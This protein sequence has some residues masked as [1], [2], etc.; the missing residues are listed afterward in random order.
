MVT[1]PCDCVFPLGG[2]AVA[3]LLGN[4]SSEQNSYYLT[5][6][7]KGEVKMEKSG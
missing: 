6:K 4:G 5:T 1:H 3:A 7:F 2:A